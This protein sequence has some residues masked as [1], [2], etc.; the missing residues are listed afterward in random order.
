VRFFMNRG[1]SH[2][3]SPGRVLAVVCRRGGISGDEVGS[4]AVHPNGTTFDVRAE[5]ARS[6][7]DRASRTDRRDPGTRIR[8]D[9]GPL[10]PGRGPE[11]R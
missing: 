4:I 8:R 7:E 3:A 5:V 11:R 1:A 10:P 6:F 9:R 2:G